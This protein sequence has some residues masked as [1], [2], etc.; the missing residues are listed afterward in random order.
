M[1]NCNKTGIKKLPVGISSLRQIIEGDYVYV[2]KTREALELIEAYK[3]VFL[4]RP[5]RFGKSLFLDT[6]CEIFSGNRELFRGLYIHDRYDF[7]PH[8]VI[9]IGFSGDLRSPAGVKNR[10]VDQLGINQKALGIACRREDVFDSCFAELIQLAFEKHQQKVVILIDEYDKAILDNLDQ[11]HVALECREVI[12]SFYSVMKDCDSYIRFVFLTGVSKFTKTSVFS[13]LNNLEDISLVPQFGKI[14]GYTGEDV[15][16]H[17][18]EILENTEYVRVEEWYNGYNF[19]GPKV[20]NPFDILLFIKNNFQFKS[21]WFE[22][23]T[24][25]FLVKLIR[26]NRYYLP[27]L[28]ALEVDSALVNSFDIEDISLETILFQAG[29]LTI[30]EVENLFGSEIYHL[31]F[32]N[33]EV[34]LSFNSYIINSFIGDRRS[35]ARRKSLYHIF[36]S[37][38]LDSLEETLRQLFASIAYNNFTNNYIEQYEGFYASVVYAYLASLGLPV[39]AEDVTSRGRMDLTIL[40]ED[41]AFIFEF[42]IREEEPLQQVHEKRYYAKYSDRKVYLIGIVFDPRERNIT[43]FTCEERPWKQVSYKGTKKRKKK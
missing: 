31:G 18:P 9:R 35:A 29:Y 12:K 13:G 38:D 15:R 17:F 23:G 24:P 22:T 6:L 39:I 2:D 40:A 34:R 28:E 33:K 3:Y 8:P 25:S 21:Y 37:A 20:F 32:P 11:V 16:H 5:R 41:K 19:F 30:L 42:K 43:R 7:A 36:M 10:L 14:C 1:K 26:E 4:S 27:N